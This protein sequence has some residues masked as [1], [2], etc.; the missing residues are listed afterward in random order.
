MTQTKLRGSFFERGIII[1][2]N[3]VSSGQSNENERVIIVY[4]HNFQF[5]D[6][7]KPLKRNVQ[8]I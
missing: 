8:V 1:I 3:E 5:T 7:D 6:K 4:I 2:I